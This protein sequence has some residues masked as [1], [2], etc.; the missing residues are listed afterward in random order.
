MME[1]I[2]GME[3]KFTGQGFMTS[4]FLFVCDTNV[5]NDNMKEPQCH[6]MQ[7]QRKRDASGGRARIHF[8]NSPMIAT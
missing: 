8:I 4:K 3:A 7:K 2:T 6:T 1:T 5:R